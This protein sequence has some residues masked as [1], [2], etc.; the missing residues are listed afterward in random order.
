MQVITSRE[1]IKK[2]ILQGSRIVLM[3]YVIARVPVMNIQIV[4]LQLLAEDEQVNIT[5]QVGGNALWSIK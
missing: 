4:H 2:L 1:N 3:K 5:H